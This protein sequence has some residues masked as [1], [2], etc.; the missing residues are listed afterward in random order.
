MLIVEL[1]GV[2]KVNIS[3]DKLRVYT[4]P[5]EFF[6]LGGSIVMKLTP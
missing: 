3:I 4:N 6:A 1:S 2:N 5:D